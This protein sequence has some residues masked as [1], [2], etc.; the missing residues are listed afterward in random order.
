[1]MHNVSYN[2]NH[3]EQSARPSLHTMLRLCLPGAQLRPPP[4]SQPWSRVASIIGTCTSI[5]CYTSLLFHA[6]LLGDLRKS[7]AEAS[8]PP[9]SLRTGHLV[10]KFVD[11]FLPTGGAQLMHEK[12]PGI[13]WSSQ[14]VW[15]AAAPC[16]ATAVC[17]WPHPWRRVPAPYRFQWQKCVRLRGNPTS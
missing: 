11:P 3:L 16:R 8:H 15:N 9:E 12:I 13:P 7:K 4:L 17:P 5:C 2:I 6:A 14:Q 1:M 10:R